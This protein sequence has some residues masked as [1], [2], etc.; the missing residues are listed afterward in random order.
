MDI[1]KIKNEIVKAA[2][3]VLKKH[4]LKCESEVNNETITIYFE[5]SYSE[6]KKVSFKY[7]QTTLDRYA[8]CPE[9]TDEMEVDGLY[10]YYMD[11]K[12]G[13]YLR[14]T[15]YDDHTIVKSGS[16]QQT[17]RKGNTYK[18]EISLWQQVQNMEGAKIMLEV[19]DEIVKL[20]DSTYKD[21]DE[22]NVK[23]INNYYYKEA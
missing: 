16:L 20:I 18:T 4:D 10:T 15:H 23:V 7:D 1:E 9:R 17:V 13:C 11:N 12:E 21:Q 8:D 14:F 2:N 5:T 19:G 22:F 6:R 3:S